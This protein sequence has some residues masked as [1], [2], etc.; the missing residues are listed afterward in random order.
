MNYLRAGMIIFG[1]ISCSFLFQSLVNHKSEII[2][3]EYRLGYLS[4]IASSAHVPM[5][6]G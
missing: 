2:I 1:R 5:Q 3:Q 4:K 6:N